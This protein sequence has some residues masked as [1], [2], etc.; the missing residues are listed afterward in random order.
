[1]NDLL[2][3]AVQEKRQNLI[4]ELIKS[5]IF[6]INNKHLYQMTLSE[7]EKKYQENST[8]HQEELHAYLQ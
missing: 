1:V 2:Q 5:G 7:L 8:Y 3:E 4:D 6:K